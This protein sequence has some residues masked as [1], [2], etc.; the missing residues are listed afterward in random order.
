MGEDDIYQR[1]S[2]LKDR[3]DANHQRVER[4][5]EPTALPGRRFPRAQT[6]DAVAASP[7]TLRAK[8]DRI[9]AELCLSPVLGIGAA[10]GEANAALELQPE[11]T[12]NQ[13]ADRLLALIG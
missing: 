11:G 1:L 8:I 9:K 13:Q 5:R 7:E 10:L 6:E 3:Q 2:A 12:L 4:R